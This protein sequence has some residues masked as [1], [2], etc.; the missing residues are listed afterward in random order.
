MSLK[1]FSSYQEA[2]DS[3]VHYKKEFL[4]IKENHQLYQKL[5]EKVY[6][7]MYKQLKNIDA[8]LREFTNERF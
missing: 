5:Y 6:L 3:M 7:K 2:K 4:P 1:R 8:T